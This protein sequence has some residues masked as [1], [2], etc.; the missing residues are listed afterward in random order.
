MTPVASPRS[1]FWALQDDATFY[2][3]VARLWKTGNPDPYFGAFLPRFYREHPGANET[4]ALEAM[5]DALHRATERFKASAV[6]RGSR[7][8]TRELIEE[9]KRLRGLDFEKTSGVVTR[10]GMEGLI[11]HYDLCP[12]GTRMIDVSLNREFVSWI[13]CQVYLGTWTDLLFFR[14]LCPRLPPHLARDQVVPFYQRYAP[15]PKQDCQVD[16]RDVLGWYPRSGFLR[17]RDRDLRKLLERASYIYAFGARPASVYD[18]RDLA[19]LEASRPE[20]QGALGIFGLGAPVQGGSGPPLITE[21]QS[22]QL[23]H[24]LQLYCLH[25]ELT[26]RRWVRIEIE[27]W[28]RVLAGADVPVR[29]ILIQG[30]EL[31]IRPTGPDHLADAKIMGVI[32]PNVFYF[33]QENQFLI[34][35]LEAARVTGSR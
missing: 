22:D 12:Y 8:Q 27:A 19:Q 10:E 21:D 6:Y 13:A 25:P 7:A 30:N 34:A 16:G 31:R 26:G 15:K 32:P 18:Y 4:R 28:Q 5:V 3:G 11:Q 9:V 23:I 24:G 2:R 33:P 14:D 20:R 29:D 35:R 1:D 17:P